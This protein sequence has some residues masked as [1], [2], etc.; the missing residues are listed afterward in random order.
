M[1]VGKYRNAQFT[2]KK[3][4]ILRPTS[5]MSLLELKK[6]KNTDLCVE[7]RSADTK[8]DACIHKKNRFLQQIEGKTYSI[9]NLKHVVH[10]KKCFLLLHV[11]QSTFLYLV[12]RL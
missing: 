1:S 12:K 3:T 5:Q 6:K 9:V 11:A 8:S 10:G 2:I 7:H 4:N